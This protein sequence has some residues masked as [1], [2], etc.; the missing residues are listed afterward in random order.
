MVAS[1][2]DMLLSA[3]IQLIRN[4][5]QVACGASS[6]RYAAIDIKRMADDFLKRLEP[7]EVNADGES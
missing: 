1:D 7:R 6:N 5:H 4:I 3:A 2:R